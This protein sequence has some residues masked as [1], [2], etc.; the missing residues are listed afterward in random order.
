MALLTAYACLIWSSVTDDFTVLNVAENSASLKPLLYK[1]T[2]TWGNHEG[3]ILLWT[4][5]LAICGG[6]VAGF[7]RN[8]PVSPPRPRASAYSASPPAAS[9]SSRCSPPTRSPASGRRRWT[10]RG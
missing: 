4:L 10:G 2:G 3:S 8:L 9:C 7:G 1:I 6:A 5:I